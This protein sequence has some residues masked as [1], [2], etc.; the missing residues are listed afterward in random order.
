VVVPLAGYSRF[1]GDDA[2]ALD[3]ETRRRI[4]DTVAETPGTHLAG[5]ADAVDEPVSTVR[6]HVR[7]LEREDVWERRDGA[8][9][10]VPGKL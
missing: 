7:V 8:W 5:V 1:G 4:H 9:W 10:V 3:H 6:Y 2:D